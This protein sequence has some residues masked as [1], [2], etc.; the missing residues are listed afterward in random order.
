MEVSFGT[1]LAEDRQQHPCANQIH[2]NPICLHRFTSS[3]GTI[4]VIKLQQ[5]HQKARGIISI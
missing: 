1:G 2:K 3:N 4:L 5:T